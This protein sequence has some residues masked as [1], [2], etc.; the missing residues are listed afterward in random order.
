[1]NERRFAP[2]STGAMMDN[3]GQEQAYQG[4]D[5]TAIHESNAMAGFP[6]FSDAIREFRAGC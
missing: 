1:M 5:G 6:H 4:A 2:I 3:D